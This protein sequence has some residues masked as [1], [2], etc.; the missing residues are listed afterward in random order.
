[1]A[2]DLAGL[3]TEVE[4][5]ATVIGS[6]VTLLNGF[7]GQLSA[8][9]AEL[10]AAGVDATKV[11]DL[12]D[13]LDAQTTALAEAVAA[14]TPAPAE[15]TPAEPTPTPEEP[16]PVTPDQPAPVTEEPTP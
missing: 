3:T 1:M 14:N 2:A 5:N 15:P 4:E 16:A 10:E 6:A 9:A 8:L 12:R 13:Q 11:N 7:G